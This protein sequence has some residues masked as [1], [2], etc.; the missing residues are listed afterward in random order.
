VR[1][2]TS[3]APAPIPAFVAAATTPAETVVRLRS[4][5]LA[6]H[7]REWFA[8]LGKQLLLDGFAA[9]TTGTFAPLLEWDRAARAAGFERPA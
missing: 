5:F 7:T 3:T 4:A 8:P 1:V 2:L 6:A 9:A